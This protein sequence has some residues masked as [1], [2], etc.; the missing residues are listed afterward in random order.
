MIRAA[1]SLLASPFWFGLVLAAGA[2]AADDGPAD[3]PP[4]APPSR[5]ITLA[6][7]LAEL[8]YAAGGGERLAGVTSYTDYPPEA[9]ALPRIGDAFRVDLERIAVIDPDL[10]LAWA[11]G[12][13]QALV[14]RLRELG[15]PLLVIRTGGVA[16]IAAA[17]RRI[18]ER[19][20]TA[21]AADRA[22]REFLLQ[23]EAAVAGH[24]EAR[25]LRVF[26]QVASRPLYTVN[27]SH[28]ISELIRRCG[29]RNVFADLGELA[30]VV[31]VESVLSRNPEVILAPGA[32]PGVLERWQAWDSVTA[33]RAGNL[34]TV[35][36][37]TLARP[38][39]RLVAGARDICAAL[40]SARGRLPAAGR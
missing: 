21:A 9:A 8:V 1:L 20:D 22:A 18:G 30:P 36:A 12:T 5:V 32:G 2:V 37:D 6:P 13:P 28:F 14:A 29:G 10:I 26:Y 4:G 24:A 7:H 19:L 3:A 27:G 40:E 25:P 31:T 39:P 23:L 34:L 16:D 15:Y 11:E 33:V 38:S 17:I 35:P